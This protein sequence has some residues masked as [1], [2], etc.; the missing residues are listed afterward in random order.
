MKILIKLFFIFL[1]FNTY[2]Q[3]RNEA[4]IDKLLKNKFNENYLNTYCIHFY[5]NNELYVLSYDSDKDYNNL[6][7]RPIFLFKKDSNNWKYASELMFVSNINYNNSI[8]FMDYPYPKAG[9]TIVNILDNDC[10]LLS[11]SYRENIMGKIYIY[12]IIVLLIPNFKNNTFKHIIFIP[13]RNNNRY[14][15][16][17]NVINNNE[18]SI[19]MNDKTN[20]NIKF[21]LL[22]LNNL[23]YNIDFIDQ[24]GNIMNINN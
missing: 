2:S 21:N 8:E 6:S 7:Q 12:P 3:I 5:Y 22:N 15:I 10:V 1:C 16:D 20:I 13:N 24:L 9:N 19:L 14:A 18:Y 23:K 11:M 17:L 4:V